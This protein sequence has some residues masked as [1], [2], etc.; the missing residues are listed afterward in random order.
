MT[1]TALTAQL[2]VTT[3]AIALLGYPQTT[4]PQAMEPEVAK[5]VTEAPPVELSVPLEVKPVVATSTRDCTPY[6]EIFNKY[7]W[8]TST[9]MEICRKES[10]GFSDAINWN[11]VH[12]DRLGNVICVS[13]RGLM[14]IACIHPAGL[15]YTL[16]DLVAAE[17]NI[18]MAYK[19]WQKS[20]FC[21]WTTAY[22]Y[23]ERLVYCQPK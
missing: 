16:E 10:R 20:G 1:F 6:V 3:L 17:K 9:A 15:G 4:H 2:V 5:T 23:E 19:I 12:K 22:T 18:H 11:D 8:P 14:Q 13:S 21:P 7:D